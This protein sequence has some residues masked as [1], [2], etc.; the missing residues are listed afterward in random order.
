[1]K[2]TPLGRVVQ[3]SLFFQI[4]FF[5]ALCFGV[6]QYVLSHFLVVIKYSLE[7]QISLQ[8]SRRRTKWFKFGRYEF[9][10]FV[11]CLVHY[12]P[13]I[14]WKAEADKIEKDEECNSF[15]ICVQLIVMC[16]FLNLKIFI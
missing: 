5:A 3:F 12:F 8:W 11:N 9:Q 2:I 4:R 15:S 7:R 6:E 14:E 13:M 16:I 1:M 10:M